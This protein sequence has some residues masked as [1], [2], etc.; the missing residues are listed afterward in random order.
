[1]KKIQK[2]AVSSCERK[3][4]LTDEDIKR[5]DTSTN[6]RKTEKLHTKNE[7]FRTSATKSNLLISSSVFQETQL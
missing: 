2:R 5:L 3:S 4:M 6:R 7:Q 1:M